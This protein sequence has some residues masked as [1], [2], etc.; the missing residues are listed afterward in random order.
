MD[1]ELDSIINNGFAVM[2][3]ILYKKLVWKSNSDGYLVRF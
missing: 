2:Y 1:K 3:M